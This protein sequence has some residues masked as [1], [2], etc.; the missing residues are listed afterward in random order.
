[1]TI[2]EMKKHEW[3][4]SWS[5]GKDSTATIILMHEFGI[6]IKEIIY[7]RMMYD[8]TLPATLPVMTNF[9]DNAKKVFE[10]WGYKVRIIKSRKTAKDIIN[11]VYFRSK[12]PEKNGSKYG[13]TAFT[14]NACRFT[15]VKQETIESCININSNKYSMI[16]YASD[17]IERIH[18]LG[19]NKQ[20]IM[21][22]LNIKEQDTFNICKHYNLLS[23]L[24]DLGIKRDGCW[25]CPNAKK[26]ERELI[27]SEYPEL[28]NKIQEMIDMCSFDV[29]SLGAVNQWINDRNL[30]LRSNGKKGV[31]Q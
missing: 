26:Y 25:F 4:V 3:V 23:P 11:K 31:N 22:E 18:R 1:M 12:Y 5:G 16:G 14:R 29:S 9:V 19:G 30:I 8:D 28:Y 15:S 6:P 2:N 7:V 27:K 21:V 17:E 20:S 10:R 13:I 24:Y